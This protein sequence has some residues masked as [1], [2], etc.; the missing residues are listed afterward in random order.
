[1]PQNTCFADR[2]L[3]VAVTGPLV[4]VELGAFQSPQAEGEK[5]QLVPGQTLV[6]PLDGFV[7]S[8]QMADRLLQQLVKDGVIKV[9]KPPAGPSTH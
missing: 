1:M 4:R 6:M 2:I 9:Q 5:P 8:M 3:N 7:A